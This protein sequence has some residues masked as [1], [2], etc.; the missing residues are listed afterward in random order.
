VNWVLILLA[1]ACLFFWVLLFM[2]LFEK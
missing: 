2:W 1:L